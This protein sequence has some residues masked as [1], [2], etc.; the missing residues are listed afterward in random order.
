MQ[1]NMRRLIKSSSALDRRAPK[2]KNNGRLLAERQ[3]RHACVDGKG[4]VA[5]ISQA[6]SSTLKAAL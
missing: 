6:L 3:T 4:K 5:E 1:V 2:R